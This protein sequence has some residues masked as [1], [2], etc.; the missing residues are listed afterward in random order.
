MKI[1]KILRGQNRSLLRDPISL[2]LSII[3][4]LIFLIIKYGLPVL[5]GYINKWVDIY[6]YYKFIKFMLFMIS[7]ML[8]GMVLG[9]L[10]MDERDQDVLTFIDITP[11]SLNR[12]IA[13]KSLIGG[14]IG[15]IFNIILALLI[16]EPFSFRIISTFVLSSFLVPFYALLI[17]KLS[18][19][20]VEA[21]TKG[22]LLTFTIAGGIIPYFVSSRWTFLLGI[23][24]PY[25]IERVYFSSTTIEIIIFL[26]AGLFLN[27]IFLK[28][29][30]K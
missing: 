9:L 25:W 1:F 21:L 18:K 20:K 30:N 17:F 7:P 15:F 11:F 6:D 12:Y 24:P 23:F 14:V 29:T 2:F 13:L 28:L 5:D 3:P 8:L 10:L 22:K 19:N 4:F 16:K 26:I 27:M